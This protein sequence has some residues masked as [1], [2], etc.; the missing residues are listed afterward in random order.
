M[1]SPELQPSSR[2]AGFHEDELLIQQCLLGD[3]I[4]WCRLVRKYAN[5]IYSIAMRRGFDQETAADIF[6]CVFAALL[7]AMS[8]IRQPR[9]L[10]GW[11]IKTAAHACDKVRNERQRSLATSLE[12]GFVSAA[13]TAPDPSLEQL[14]RE[15]IVQ[16]AVAAQGTECQKLIRLLFFSDPPVSYEIAA[17]QLG[18]SKGSIG[19]T[20]MRCL[21]KLRQTLAESNLQ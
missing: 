18:L 5:L 19:A 17:E 6:Q 8:G 12:Y 9:A 20:R 4:A 10:A 1:S 14:E 16:Q 2:S 7:P 21:E 15:R 13:V 11:L 3:E